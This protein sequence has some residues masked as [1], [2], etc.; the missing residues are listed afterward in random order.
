[1]GI[2]I[3]FSALSTS[4]SLSLRRCDDR[5]CKVNMR[6]QRHSEHVQRTYNGNSSDSAVVYTIP[7]DEVRGH[8]GVHEVR[9]V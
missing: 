4:A 7:G 1:L 8:V 2:V 6:D 5:V 3:A 9:G